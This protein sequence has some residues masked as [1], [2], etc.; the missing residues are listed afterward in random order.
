MAET[1]KTADLL[2][3]AATEFASAKAGQIISNIGDRASGKSNGSN[4]NG[5]QDDGDG[6]DGEEKKGFLGNAAEKLGE[7]ASPVGA[8]VK[9]LGSTIKEGVGGLFKRKSG[10]KRPH[11]IVEDI[12]VG[13]PRDVC[14]A[15]FVQWEEFPSFM[16]GPENVARGEEK[17][18]DELEEG[19]HPLE[20][21]ETNWSAKIFM[22]KRSW[23]ATTVDFDPPQRVSWKSEGAKGKVDGTITLTEIGDNATLMAIEIE[24]WSKGPVEWMGQRWHTVGKRVRLDMKHFRRYVMRTE[25]EELEE[26][27]EDNEDIETEQPEEQPAEG[28]ESEEPTDEVD[29]ADEADEVEVDDPDAEVE[30]VDE[31]EPVDETEDAEEEPEE[32]EPAPAR[33][34]RPRRRAPVA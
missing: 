1:P 27:A 20:G 28:E 17:N 23:K 19:E 24:Y 26:M 34:A 10:S 13:V 8:A 14:W 2:T 15:A 3:K 22:S 32:P 11:N 6:D 9:G 7:G 25:P 29:E 4:G 16:K 18:E 12:I 31:E 5:S 30:E 21:E 33:R